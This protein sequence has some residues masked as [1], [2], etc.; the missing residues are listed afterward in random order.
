LNLRDATP[1]DASAIAGIYNHFIVH[2]TIS[3]EEDTVADA[4]MAQR[5]AEIQ[6]AGMPWLVAE[7][8]GNV[9][10]YA[11]ATK[12]RARAAYRYAVESSVYL[13]ADFAGQGLGSALYACLLAR[14]RESG[15]HLVV[16]G[17]ALPNPASVALHE[18]MGFEKVAHFSE[19]GLKFG[20]WIDVGYWQRKL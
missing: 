5:I 1:A 3:F 18:K 9:A 16:G 8:D 7:V 2:T 12:W 13:S 14:L 11:Y 19:V 15:K 10:G 17:I 4:V 20:R 6:E